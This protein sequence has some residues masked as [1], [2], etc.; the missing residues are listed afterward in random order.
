M[1]VGADLSNGASQVRFLVL[2]EQASASLLGGRR[3]P[4]FR[5]PPGSAPS[6]VKAH[7]PLSRSLF[8]GRSKQFGLA[9][10]IETKW[11]D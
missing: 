8:G 5:D 6:M 10:Q 7:R 4:S 9:G 1:E 11:L 3:P 2:D